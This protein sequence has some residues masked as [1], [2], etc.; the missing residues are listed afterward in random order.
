MPLGRGRTADVYAT[1][2]GAWVL[3]R[4]RDG[5]ETAR[6]AALMVRS[7][8]PPP[9]TPG[10]PRPRSPRSSRPV[11]AL[12]GSRRPVPSGPPTRT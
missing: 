9:P 11:P 6:E 8:S 12:S 2:D 7:P 10:A 1:D 5:G 4:Y 3:R